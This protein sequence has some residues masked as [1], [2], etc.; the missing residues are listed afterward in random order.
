VKS[1]GRLNK[2]FQLELF[3]L[4]SGKWRNDLFKIVIGVFAKT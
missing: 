4:S 2:A 1:F 3:D